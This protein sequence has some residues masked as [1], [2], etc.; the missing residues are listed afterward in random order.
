M[1]LIAVALAAIGLVILE[2]SATITATALQYG[3]P[4]AVALAAVLEPVE[5][6]TTTMR[7]HI[8]QLPMAV[9]RPSQTMATRTGLSTDPHPAAAPPGP[10]LPAQCGAAVAM[11][12]VGTITLETSATVT[13]TT[14]QLGTLRQ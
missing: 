13:S 10:S 11:A 9:L 8:L 6:T 2:T 12:A 7:M 5:E 4:T 1:H 14:T 3:A